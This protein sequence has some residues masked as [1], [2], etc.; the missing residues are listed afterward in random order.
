MGFPSDYFEDVDSSH[1]RHKRVRINEM[2]EYVYPSQTVSTERQSSRP[3]S[4]IGDRNRVIDFMSNNRSETDLT[5]SHRDNNIISNSDSSSVNLANDTEDE[6]NRMLLDPPPWT[7]SQE[8]E[9]LLRNSAEAARRN[10]RNR[11]M[12]RTG[13]L[14]RTG[15][16]RRRVPPPPP[17]AYTALAARYNHFGNSIGITSNNIDSSV[18]NRRLSNYIIPDN[19]ISTPANLDTANDNNITHETDNIAHETDN[20]YNIYGYRPY[21]EP[22]V[23]YN[24][25]STELSDPNRLVDNFNLAEPYNRDLNNP[26][27]EHTNNHTNNEDDDDDDNDSYSAGN[28]TIAQHPRAD[29]RELS[30]LGRRRFGWRNP[31][32]PS[33]TSPQNEEL[34]ISERIRR[35]S[36]VSAQLE[37]E[38]QRRSMMPSTTE[39]DS[40]LSRSRLIRIFLRNLR[41]ADYNFSTDRDNGNNTNNNSN[42][43]TNFINR[44]PPDSN[45][46]VSFLRPLSRY[47]LNGSQGPEIESDGTLTDSDPA[48]DSLVQAGSSTSIPTTDRLLQNVLAYKVI[49][50]SS[51]KSNSVNGDNNSD[52]NNGSSASALEDTESSWPS[53]VISESFYDKLAAESMRKYGTTESLPSGVS[54]KKI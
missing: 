13:L 21:L 44:L 34:T 2:G 43:R 54:F 50:R 28:D 16:I 31:V 26:D 12:R 49:S 22:N 45:E 48:L 52:D 20:H 8:T 53:H 19:S 23:S 3:R 11:N 14:R 42:N 7:M 36:E 38:N 47:T 24:Q 46:M 6:R 39:D 51:I 27:T 37:I 5:T 33:I 29:E 1:T 41:T 35:R 32:R 10:R 15:S 4:A 9:D 30:M 18:N 40:R 17:L 25:I